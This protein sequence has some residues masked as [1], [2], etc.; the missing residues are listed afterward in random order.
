MNQ[1]QVIKKK[2]LDVIIKN[3]AMEA[4]L[5]ISP[6]HGEIYTVQDLVVALNSSQVVYGIKEDQLQKIVKEK[7]FG[8]EVLVAEGKKP[9]NGENGRY[10]ILFDT[11]VDVKPKILADGSVDYKSMGHVPVV[12]ENEEIA[13]YYPA[14]PPQSGITVSGKEIGGKKGKDFRVLKGKGFVVSEDKRS[15]RAAFTG[16]A[17]LT[18]GVLIVSKVLV[19]EDNVTVST[20]TLDFQG[21]IVIKGDVLTGSEVIATGNVEV[22]GCVEAANITAGR[23]VVLKFGMQGNGKGT[24]RAG[25]NVSGKFFEQAIIHA[26]GNVSSNAIMN[27]EV[28]CGDTVNVVGRYGIIVGGNIVALRKV[29]ATLIGN[30]HERKTYIQVG[31]EEDLCGVL[32]QLEDEDRQA[33]QE[34]SRHKSSVEELEA[35]IQKHPENFNLQDRKL[36]SLHQIVELEAKVQEFQNKKEEIIDKMAKVTNPLVVARKSIYPGCVL[37]IKGIRE[38]IRTENYNV[39]YRCNGIEVEFVANIC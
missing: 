38:Q 5:R 28:D 11:N 17:T 21:D 8:K 4:Y 15:Y 2:G 31:T 25:G 29:E 10:E 1:Q 16:R 9:K 13:R 36:N 3:E 35:L 6:E 32:A 33:V 23:N 14:T 12:Q 20:G 37:V 7:I 24:V 22:D 27:C 26:K 30:M 34:L 19:I 18:S 39:T